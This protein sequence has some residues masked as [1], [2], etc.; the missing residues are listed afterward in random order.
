[1]KN[2]VPARLTIML[3]AVLAISGVT[4]TS[5]AAP[6]ED[7]SHSPDVRV[8]RDVQTLQEAIDSAPDHGRI[9]VEGGRYEEVI[10][11]SGKTLHLVGE[12]RPKIVGPFPERANPELPNALSRTE[13]LVN[14]VAGG[15]GSIRGFSFIGGDA[16]IMGF[17]ERQPPGELLAAE[18]TIQGSG[19]G[20]V[21]SH[22]AVSLD[23]VN[24]ADTVYHAILVDR[25][26]AF[27]LASSHIS[28]SAFG[29]GVL[30]IGTGCQG[31]PAQI[32]DAS[33]AFNSFGGI[34]LSNSCALIDNAFLFVNA[35]AG[36][37]L[38]GS[39]A[40]VTNSHVVGTAQ[41]PV[42]GNWGDGVIAFPGQSGTQSFLWLADSV[43]KDSRRAG[44]SNFGS[45]G[46][47]TNVTIQCSAFELQ[48]EHLDAGEFGSNNPPNPLSFVWHDEGGNDCGCPI[49]DGE[50]VSI[51][52]TISPPEPLP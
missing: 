48:G 33:S 5:F 38:I 31:Q 17:E 40:D 8:P 23:S 52:S 43:I 14:Y 22:S 11:I 28:N 16:A 6:R 45:I 51:S 42:T 47:L 13:G 20:I 7:R 50:C 24:I 35:V 36:I 32:K 9:V 29:A 25:V 21:W 30:V 2:L 27:S 1:M 18:L 19:Q 34:V 49:A 46:T 41:S 39:V 3:T 12:G 4:P 37:W 15:G 26:S 44:V 10:T